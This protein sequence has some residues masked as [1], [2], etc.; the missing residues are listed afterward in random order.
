MG[1]TV[2]KELSVGGFDDIPQAEH[3]HPPLTT[4]RQPVYEIGQRISRMLIELIQEGDLAERHVVLTPELIVRRS[5]G[6]MITEN[7]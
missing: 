4:V 6:P 3:A 2:G 5:S 1:L 7:E